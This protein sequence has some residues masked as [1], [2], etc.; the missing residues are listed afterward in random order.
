M[1]GR[2][3]QL[4]ILRASGHE[5][6][7]GSIVISIIA[8]DGAIAEIYGRKITTHG[9]RPGTPVHL[10]LPGPHKGVW[11]LPVFHASK[12]IILCE[13][14][15]DAL[16][17]WCAGYRN[18]TASYGVE[19]FT[20]D[21]LA[22]FQEYGIE[23]V[24]IAYDRDDAGEKGAKKVAAP[25]LPLG[26]GC[27]R[28]HFPKGMDANEYALKTQPAE[29]SL[30]LVL[31]AATWM[32][33]GQG[34]VRSPESAER[35]PRVVVPLPTAVERSITESEP[36]PLE[37]LVSPDAQPPPADPVLPIEHAPPA[38]RH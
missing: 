19:G 36:L 18:V 31:K 9:L 35:P 1:R 28:V 14:L 2:L 37:A 30:G 20:A 6:F 26:I 32:G 17:F 25:L 4:G 13:A 11:N 34:L 29:K 15:I 10:Y 3:Q 5:H 38:R 22:A 27:Y 21:H 16:T 24:F 8:A 23:K 12:E 7:H 33:D